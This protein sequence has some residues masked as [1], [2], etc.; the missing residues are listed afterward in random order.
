MLVEHVGFDTTEVLRIIELDPHIEEERGNRDT[1]T[2]QIF[3]CFPQ[4]AEADLGISLGRS[5]M[6]EGIVA[7][8]LP[9]CAIVPALGEEEI[10]ER[11]GVR[12]VSHPAGA[13]NAEVQGAE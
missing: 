3:L 11:V 13:G 1:L 9:S 5:L 10:K 12:V 2:D 7:G 6:D 8:V 4:D